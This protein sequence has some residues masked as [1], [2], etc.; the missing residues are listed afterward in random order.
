MFLSEDSLLRDFFN[1]TFHPN[2]NPF[3]TAPSLL[4]EDTEGGYTVTELI[5]EPIKQL[6]TIQCERV[7]HVIA[8][9][10]F[11][12]L[13]D[14]HTE[15]VFTG[16]DS[17]GKFTFF[18]I[19]I[20]C[21]FDDLSLISQTLLVPTGNHPAKIGGLH[22]IG[23]ILSGQ[24]QSN[25]IAAIIKGFQE[26]LDALE[27]NRTQIFQVIFSSIRNHEAPLRVIPRATNT[28]K[29]YL[30]GDLKTNELPFYP[31]EIQQLERGDI[32]YYF[33]Y[34][35]SPAIRFYSSKGSPTVAE[36][37]KQISIFN[38]PKPLIASKNGLSRTAM[39]PEHRKASILQISRY[40]L[41]K[42]ST[43]KASYKGIKIHTEKNMIYIN[44]QDTL[45]IKGLFT[46]ATV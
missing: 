43:Y 28:Y 33:R 21:L 22:A 6:T 30:T 10:V 37:S 9:S 40:L 45:K 16:V 15:N 25:S 44:Y 13:G 39:S 42:N 26:Q 35:N 23:N 20:E 18:P 29:S 5:V 7:G 3:Y 24:Q 36:L 2:L 14:L 11:F 8:L 41:S 34:L 12:G 31:S 19:D 46:E 17:K 1:K 27:D 38:L 32:P 4:F